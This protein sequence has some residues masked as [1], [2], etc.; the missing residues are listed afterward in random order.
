MSINSPPSASADK[1]HARSP[2]RRILPWIAVLV[3]FPL[4]GWEFI[5]LQRHA[6]G[7]KKVISLI[8]PL[9]DA[10]SRAVSSKMVQVALH[11]KTPSVVEDVSGRNLSNGGAKLEVYRWF[12]LN[13]GVKRELFVY[14]ASGPDAIAIC[15]SAEEDLQTAAAPSRP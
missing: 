10:P 6:Q 11:G 9:D 12:S 2:L 13:P 8:G 14:Y 1:T 4:L 7:V 15:A 5:S 3:L